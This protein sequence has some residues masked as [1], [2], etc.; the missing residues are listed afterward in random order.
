MTK[1]TDDVKTA[2][3]AEILGVAT[4]DWSYSSR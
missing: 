3:A 1:V 4:S 2:E